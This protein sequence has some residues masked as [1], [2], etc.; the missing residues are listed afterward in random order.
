M[1]KQKDWVGFDFDGTLAQYDGWK[2]VDH[3][4]EPIPS[5]VERLKNYLKQGMEVRIFTARI[6]EG[7]ERGDSQAAAR[8]KE[9]CVKHI[10]QELPVTNVKDH[11]LVN[12][13]DD[14]AIAVEP[15]TGRILGGVSRRYKGNE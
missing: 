11:G 9:W 13:Y 14:R 7:E 5:M 12:L 10:G 8:I 3:L 15:N 4:G 6:S 2:G 1:S